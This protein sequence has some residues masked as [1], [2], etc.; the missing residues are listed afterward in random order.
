MEIQTAEDGAIRQMNE[1]VMQP[2]QR[3]PRSAQFGEAMNTVG[4]G[5]TTVLNTATNGVNSVTQG[6]THIGEGF[7]SIGKGVGSVF[8]W[9]GR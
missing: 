5:L 3:S 8:G 9:M 6:I 7:S 1:N 4:D 2:H